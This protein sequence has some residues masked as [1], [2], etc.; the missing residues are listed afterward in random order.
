[1][2]T[3]PHPWKKPA[4]PT[5]QELIAQKLREAEIALLAAE[6]EFERAKHSKAMFLERVERL[7]ALRPDQELPAPAIPT[8]LLKV[9]A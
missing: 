3:I 2:F 5:V 9:A 7:R 1:M 8:T 6:E 4:D